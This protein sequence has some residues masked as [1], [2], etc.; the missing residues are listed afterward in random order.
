MALERLDVR[1]LLD[2]N[3]YVGTHLELDHG[4]VFVTESPVLRFLVPSLLLWVEWFSRRTSDAQR[5]RMLSGIAGCYVAALLSRFAQMGVFIHTRP[6]PSTLPVKI[7]P[8][9]DME[10]W[11]PAHQFSSFPSDFAA[12][13][14]AV[15]TVIFLAN[16]KFG[17]VA[18]LWSFVVCGVARVYLGI[19]YP[20]DIAAGALIGITTVLLFSREFIAARMAPLVRL[21]A[22]RPA[23]FYPVLVLVVEQMWDAFDALLFVRLGI[24]KLAETLLR[25][26]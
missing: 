13:F 24:E 17:A 20:S 5:A 16:R 11:S 22:T 10:Q 23:V 4:V 9:L 7:V 1:L 3:G 15:A 18:Y 14:F 6:I 21:S 26:L 12:L 19:H 25:H 2:L 8:R